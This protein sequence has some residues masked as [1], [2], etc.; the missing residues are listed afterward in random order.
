MHLLEQLMLLQ[1]AHLIKS[2]REVFK[3]KVKVKEVLIL[4]DLQDRATVVMDQ[5]LSAVN[6]NV[7]IAEIEVTAKI[8]HKVDLK[9]KRLLRP[10]LC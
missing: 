5:E 4:A 1:L 8:D 2:L 9:N 10:I 7:G 6:H 3:L